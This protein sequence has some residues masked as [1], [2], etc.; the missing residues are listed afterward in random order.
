MRNGLNNLNKN[1]IEATECGLD[2]P[3]CNYFAY[4]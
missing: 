4:M 3:R 1:S 2:S